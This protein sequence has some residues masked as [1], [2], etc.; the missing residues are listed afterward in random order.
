[1]A[2]AAVAATLGAASSSAAPPIYLT[3][4]AKSGAGAGFISTAHLSCP[5]G[6]H[7]LS[8]GY[9]ATSRVKVVASWPDSDTSWAVK[10]TSTV[11]SSRVYY[12][13]IRCRT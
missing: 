7:V 3:K 5:V 13:F 12:V 8:G 4:A 1:V 9:L 11:S 6:Y 10:A 2:V